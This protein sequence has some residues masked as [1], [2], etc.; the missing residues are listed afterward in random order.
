MPSIRLL[1]LVHQRF[2]PHGTMKWIPWQLRLSAKQ[3]Q[4]IIEA[5]TSKT[6]RTEAQLIS[7]ALFDE[8]PEQSI[9]KAYLSP[10]WLSKCQ[11]VMRNAIALCNGA[12]LRILKAFDAKVF[13]LATQSL[14]ADSGLRTVHTAELLQADRKLWSELAA[15]HSD[16]WSLDQ[17]LHEMTK[18]RSD[19][20]ALL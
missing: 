3:Y 1:S 16:G 8:T 5:R 14:G 12:H 7:T 9:D 11:T 4:E 18:V 17:A 20:H 6:L 19:M 2:R 10:A 15:M 13:E